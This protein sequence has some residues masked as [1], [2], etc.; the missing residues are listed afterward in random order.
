MGITAEHIGQPM[1]RRSNDLGVPSTLI[2]TLLRIDGIQNYRNAGY[3]KHFIVVRFIFI[4][5]H[6]P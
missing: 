6:N 5:S 4:F 3:G 1:I 2:P